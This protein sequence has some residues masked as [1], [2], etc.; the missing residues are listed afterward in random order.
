MPRTL[1][2]IK[3]T[4]TINEIMFL[5]LEY[6]VVCDAVSKTCYGLDCCTDGR[7][8]IALEKVEPNVKTTC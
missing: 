8:S 2:M 6:N 3:S 4:V 5:I 7:Y 1:Q